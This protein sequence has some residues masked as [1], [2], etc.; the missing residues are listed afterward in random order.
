M[1]R[2]QSLVVAVILALVV[3]VGAAYGVVRSQNPKPAVSGPATN[4][5]PGT[6]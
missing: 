3:A 1:R 4:Y 6:P 2:I 5:G